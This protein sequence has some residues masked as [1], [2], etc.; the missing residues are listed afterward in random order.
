MARE[1]GLPVTL[2]R[3][4]ELPPAEEMLALEPWLLDTDMDMD[5]DM[6]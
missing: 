2:L 3:R 4:D 6:D 1:S 5:M